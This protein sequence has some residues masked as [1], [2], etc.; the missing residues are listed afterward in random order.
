MEAWNGYGSFTT[1]RIGRGTVDTKNLCVSV[2][3][4]IQP[5]KLTRYLYQANSNLQN[6]GLIQRMQLL[7][8]PDEPAKWQLVD[9]YPDVE[10][11]NR[12]FAVFKALADMDFTEHGAELP[13][14]EQI[15]F[16]HFSDEAQEI[17][18]EWLTDLQG[19]L[20]TEEAPLMVEHMAKYRSLMPSMALIFH[21]IN[22]ASGVPGGPVSFLAAQ[23]AAAWCDYLESHARRIYGLVADVSIRAAGEL[24]KKIQAGKV[25][26]GFTVRDIY[27][28]KAWHLLDKKELV[29]DACS[30]LVEAGW[31]REHIP[32]EGKTR[33]I[34]YINPKIF[35]VNA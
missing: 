25:H 8:Y 22:I 9:E 4:G 18:N 17:F 24:A 30:E 23:Q 33:R 13:E 1:D 7:V 31:L 2:L 10:A 14:G 15:P 12:V 19:R 16:F 21:L 5:S 20:Q 6:D 27:N 34:Y 3:G 28:R 32:E 35:S 29:Q 11:K 26:D